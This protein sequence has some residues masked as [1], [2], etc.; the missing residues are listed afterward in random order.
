MLRLTLDCLLQGKSLSK[1]QAA[2]A[3]RALLQGENPSQ[4]AAFLALLKSKGETVDELLG[5]LEAVKERSVFVKFDTP[6]LDI[7]GTGGDGVGTV[8]LSTGAALLTAACGVP[9]VKHG[10]RAVSSQ[11]G[12]ADVLEEL[13]FDIHLGP[14]PL[15]KSVKNTIFKRFQSKN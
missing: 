14:E 11:C 15:K 4:A 9:V 5:L 13:G 12:S 6:V 8:N 10:N 3:A 2:Q 1:E 7:V